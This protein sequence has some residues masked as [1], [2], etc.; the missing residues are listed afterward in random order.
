MATAVY[1][2]AVQT[3]AGTYPRTDNVSTVVANDVNL[4][5]VE[6]T[7]IESTLGTAPTT[8][9]SWGSGSFTQG[10]SWGSVA[11]R[12]Q[13]IETGLYTAYTDRMKL[14]GANVL[15]L[16]GTTAGIT[17]STSGTGNLLVVGNTTFDKSGYIVLDGGTA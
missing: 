11:A 1:P 14:S 12:I 10:T 5:Y 15:S 6:V 8:S 4:V 2:S 7:A 9:A 16:S 17:L 3:F 13:N